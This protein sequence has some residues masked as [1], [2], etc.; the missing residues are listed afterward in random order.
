MSKKI[1]LKI[2]LTAKYLCF[3]MFLN[4]TLEGG[5]DGKS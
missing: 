2:N 4:K 1:L 3:T 5:C